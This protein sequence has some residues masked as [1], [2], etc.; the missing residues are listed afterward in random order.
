[1]HVLLIDDDRADRANL[2]RALSDT[3]YPVIINEADSVAAAF[4]AIDKHVP[5]VVLLDYQM[6]DVDGFDGLQEIRQRHPFLPIVMVTGC[7]SELLAA[8]AIQSGADDYIPKGS[9]SQENLEHAITTATAKANL[10]QT[11]FDQQQ[12]LE[13]FAHMLSHD[14]RAPLGRI[15]SFAELV[16]DDVEAGRLDDLPPLCKQL[17][18]AAEDALELVAMLTGFLRSPDLTLESLQLQVLVEEAADVIKAERANDNAVID[19]A[20]MSVSV[21]SSRPLLL[22]IFQNLLGNALKYNRDPKPRVEVRCESSGAGYKLH[23]IDNGIGIDPADQAGI[24]EPFARLHGDAE[25]RGTGLGLAIC[26]KN[27]NRLGGSLTVSSRGEGG[28]CF[29][30]WLP[31]VNASSI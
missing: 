9:I 25:F 29:T 2:K 8:R 4:T 17:G 21:H 7:G 28:S 12:E 19:I 27:I 11:I 26:R 6:P 18:N 13:H 1:M 24:F 20:P 14:L 30:L 5:D 10:R 3:D 16:V 31:D 15:R 22:Q 23:F